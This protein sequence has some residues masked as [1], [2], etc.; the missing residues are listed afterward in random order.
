MR[1]IKQNILW[2]S[3]AILTGCGGNVEQR[4]NKKLGAGD[5][6]LYEEALGDIGE[7]NKAAIDK[8]NVLELNYP[9]SANL[10][11]A[12][13][14]KIYALYNSQDY[15]GAAR[16]SEKFIA[17]YPTHRNA[18][19]AYYIKGM[20]SQMQIMDSQRDQQMTEEALM[21]FTELEKQFPNSSYV[22]S[23]KIMSKDSQNLL[24]VK[25]V[26]IGRSYAA[27]GQYAAAADRYL[28]VIKTYPNS[29]AA[30]EAIYRMVEVHINLN[31]P[32]HAHK[33][34]NMLKTRHADSPWTEKA[35]EVIKY[36]YKS[37]DAN[38]QGAKYPTKYLEI[39]DSNIR[40][41]SN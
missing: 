35:T 32:D 38:L 23:V 28:F 10:P 18:A 39:P 20:C 5:K 25:Q 36:Q 17:L 3:L 41:D 19:Y 22:K 12:M 34:C 2:I 4:E 40:F 6:I 16:Q 14:L 11:E 9:K 33:Y 30:P 26:E 29:S 24:A 21:A 8:L 27:K 15:I 31:A 13:T 7:N 37:Q 1:Y